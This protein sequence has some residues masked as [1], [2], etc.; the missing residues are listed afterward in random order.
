MQSTDIIRKKCVNQRMPNK[1][2]KSEI[3]SNG[4][5]L[6]TKSQSLV[7]VAFFNVSIKQISTVTTVKVWFYLPS[8]RLAILNKSLEVLPKWLQDLLPEAL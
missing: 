1:N 2:L 7:Y 8:F 6:L 3:Q 5:A 4:F